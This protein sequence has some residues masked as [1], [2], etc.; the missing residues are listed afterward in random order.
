MITICASDPPRAPPSPPGSPRNLYDSRLAFVVWADEQLRVF[1]D[2][3]T[4]QL[5]NCKNLGTVAECVEAALK[6]CEK[7]ILLTD[8]RHI[9][10]A[11]STVSSQLCVAGLDFTYTMHKLMLES[12][13]DSINE[14]RDR[15]IEACRLKA[16]V[17]SG[18]SSRVWCIETVSKSI[19]FRRRRGS[20][21][22]FAPTRNC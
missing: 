17:R 16:A 21:W 7:V 20:Q 6:E 14:S 8:V 5:A 10:M 11:T 22:I 2:Q 1:V 12:L 9:A 4:R 3:F 15:L 18:R 19:S 13:A